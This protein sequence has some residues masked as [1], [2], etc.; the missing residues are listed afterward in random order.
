MQSTRPSYSNYQGET[1]G[2]A[3]DPHDKTGNRIVL[4]GFY[5]IFRSFDKGKTW[6]EI[7]FNNK[8]LE[9]GSKQDWFYL[10]PTEGNGS[11][12]FDPH[13]LGS[14]YISDPYMIWQTKDIWAKNVVFS[15]QYKN[16][17]NLVGITLIASPSS[18]SG[19]AAE[20]YSG[21]SDIRGFRHMNTESYPEN[22]SWL[23]DGFWGAYTTGID[24]CEEN[25]DFV[26]RV[27]EDYNNASFSKI[28]T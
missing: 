16:L 2:I 26:M 4:I 18:V 13:Q 22:L 11:L 9:I 6:E 17:E 19:N 27:D 20:L 10:K 28:Y 24:F 14:A 1:R 25:P 3:I 21:C 8:R 7:S 12:A 5:A 15:A 23:Y